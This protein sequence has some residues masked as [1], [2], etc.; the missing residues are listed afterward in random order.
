MELGNA[1][2]LYLLIV[3]IFIIIFYKLNLTIWASLLYAFVIGLAVLIAVQPPN[4]IDPWSTGSES[5]SAIYILILF[6]TPIYV[7]IYALIKGWQDKRIKNK[8]CN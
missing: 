4:E 5:T 7:V 2:L 8:N 6:L 3:I 1:L